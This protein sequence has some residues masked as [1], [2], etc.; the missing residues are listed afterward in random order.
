MHEDDERFGANASQKEACGDFA[1]TIMGCCNYHASSGLN[2]ATCATVF[3]VRRIGHSGANLLSGSGIWV[4]I[5]VLV[6]SILPETDTDPDWGQGLYF[7]FSHHAPLLQDSAA[8][9]I[10]VD[11]PRMRARGVRSGTEMNEFVLKE[12]SCGDHTSQFWSMMI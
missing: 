9:T 4:G 11:G 2:F 10:L 1:I 5:S 8:L 6:W 7:L 3:Q 12:S